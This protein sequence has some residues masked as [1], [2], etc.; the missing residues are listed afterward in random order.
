[1]AVVRYNTVINHYMQNT[2]VYVASAACPIPNRYS[3]K[4]FDTSRFRNVL[5]VKESDTRIY[6]KFGKNPKP[7]HLSL[8]FSIRYLAYTPKDLLKI[9]FSMQGGGSIE[10]MMGDHKYFCVSNSLFVE[11]SSKSF[12]RIEPVF[13]STIKKDSG[14]YG[15]IIFSSILQDL[16]S[17]LSKTILGSLVPLICSLGGDVKI[18][19]TNTICEWSCPN[20]EAK[21]FTLSSKLGI[22]IAKY[23][24]RIWWNGS[25]C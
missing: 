9:V 18:D 2:P 14:C 23:Y 11:T 3:N 4:G 22:E 17:D 1:M 13:L 8:S 7:A 19:Q 16:P 15:I 12:N 10:I 25:G 24:E 6:R 5:V 21:P 20:P